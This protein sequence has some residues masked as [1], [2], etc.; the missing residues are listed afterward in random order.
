MSGDGQCSVDH[1]TR[2][3]CPKCRLKR[4]V[5]VG[6]KKEFLMT[7]EEKQR[8]AEKN[9]KIISTSQT[10]NRISPPTISHS[11]SA[12]EEIDRVRFLLLKPHLKTHR[13]HSFSS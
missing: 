4:C 2:R 1:L 13:F 11:P 3:K 12:D 7:N 9:R 8:R 6:M 10:T 5:E